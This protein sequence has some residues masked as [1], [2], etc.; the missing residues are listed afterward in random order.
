M[1]AL[2]SFLAF[3][4]FGLFALL[5]L[6]AGVY[7]LAK[8]MKPGRIAAVALL[9]FAAFAIFCSTP[10]RAADDGLPLFKAGE[11]QI[12]LLG[13]GRIEDLTNLSETQKGAGLG[14][15]YFPWR[16]AGFGL[17]ARGEG[18]GLLVDSTAFSLIGR[19]PLEALRLAPEIKLGTDYGWK[20]RDWAVFAGV[21]LDYRLS[22][23]VAIAG[24]LRGVRPIAGAEGEHILA[25]LKLRFAF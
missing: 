15:N 17:E 5:V 24:E 16:S 4:V 1:T 13:T 18:R 2:L 6:A 19:Y 9:A 20:E 11:T 3:L 22:R 14:V 10:A 25:L 7:H 12:D 23:N 21:G 8:K